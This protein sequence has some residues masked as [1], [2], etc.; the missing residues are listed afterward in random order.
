MSGKGWG[1]RVSERMKQTLESTPS[2]ARKKSESV[3]HTGFRSMAAIARWFLD[4]NDVGCRV[5]PSTS[6]SG[7]SRDGRSTQRLVQRGSRCT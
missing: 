4:D 5:F 6:G 1:S 3:S 2:R 7:N